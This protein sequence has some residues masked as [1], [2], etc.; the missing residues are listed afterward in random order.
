MCFFSSLCSVK[1]LQPNKNSDL[2]HHILQSHPRSNCDKSHSKILI[3]AQKEDFN[4]H[5]HNLFLFQIQQN[6]MQ[7]TNKR[8]DK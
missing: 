1:K 3:R 7:I 8:F 4:D 2:Y 6:K 5:H